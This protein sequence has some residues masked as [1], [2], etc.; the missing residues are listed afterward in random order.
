MSA[1]SSHSSDRESRANRY[2]E[3]H[4]PGPQWSPV[5]LASTTDANPVSHRLFPTIL[6]EPRRGDGSER[7]EKT[8]RHQML[9]ARPEDDHDGSDDPRNRDGD[10]GRKPARRSVPRVS[11]RTRWA[12]SWTGKLLELVWVHARV[13]RQ[14]EGDEDSACH[15][16]R[17]DQRHEQALPSHGPSMP[18]PLW[19]FQAQD[20]DRRLRA[21][22][23]EVLDQGPRRIPRRARAAGTMCALQGSPL[24]RPRRRGEARGFHRASKPGSCR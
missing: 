21:S 24:G 6:D 10:L 8:N 7:D 3:D 2:A 1:R 14:D 22:R 5:D 15:Q 9:L 18:T 20:P 11:K 12:T 23:P 16:E 19:T 17:T 13:H 4:D